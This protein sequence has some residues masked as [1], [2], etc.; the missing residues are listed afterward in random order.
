MILSTVPGIVTVR[1]SGIRAWSRAFSAI[2]ADRAMRGSEI[3]LISLARAASLDFAF[4]F[5]ERI[6]PS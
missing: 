1:R 5:L 6:H 4:I 3:C 2:L